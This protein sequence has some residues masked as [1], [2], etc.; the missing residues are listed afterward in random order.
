MAP[1]AVVIDPEFYKELKAI[2]RAGRRDIVKRILRALHMLEEDPVVARPGLDVKPLAGMMGRVFRLRVGDYRV[3][4]E[5][6]VKSRQVFVTTVFH[7]S[8]GYRL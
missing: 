8:R 6:D 1:F 7:R 2:E 4:Y 3:L 5:V